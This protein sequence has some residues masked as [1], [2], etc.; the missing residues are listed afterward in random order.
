MHQSPLLAVLRHDSEFA[1]GQFLRLVE[2]RDSQ[3]SD[4]RLLVTPDVQRFIRYGL[5]EH[6][7]DL[8]VVVEKMLRSTLPKTSQSGARLASIALLLQYDNAED[9]V[10]EALRG[11]SSQRLG[12][13]QVASGNIGEE[14]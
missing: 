10:E 7:E 3:P 2:S 13:A 8:Q 14:A 6:F 1:L 12:V 5:Y 9:L 4:D 11:N